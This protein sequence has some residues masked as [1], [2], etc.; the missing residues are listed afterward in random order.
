MRFIRH[1]NF[2]TVLSGA[3]LF[4]S[5]AMNPSCFAQW[6]GRE[7]V[8]RQVEKTFGDP[9]G[10]VR[11]DPESRVWAD[12]KH[13]RI[14]VDGC[15]ALT[16]GQLE[17]F[18]CTV[19]TKEHESVV[20]VFS[21]AHVIHTGLLAVGAEKGKPV[22]WDPQYQPPTGSEIQ[23]FVLWRDKDGKKRNIDARRWIRQ[24]GTKDQILDTNFVF[25]GS[26]MWTDPETGEQRYMA[27]SGDLICVSNFSTA[28]LDVPMESSAVNSGLMFAAFTDRIPERDTPVRLVLQ[29]VKP[30]KSASVLQPAR[31]GEALPTSNG[32]TEAAAAKDET[33]GSPNFPSLDGLADPP[34]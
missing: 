25:A 21:R 18:A 30:E 7:A 29:V 15:I 12:K 26:M 4:L 33:L 14:V 11:L 9:P 34:Q 27:E 10:M 31:P 8:L 20:A 13:R 3:C 22:Q 19:G 6:E 2:L 24:I 28:T 16:S 32:T 5:Q 17:M 1:S 23:V